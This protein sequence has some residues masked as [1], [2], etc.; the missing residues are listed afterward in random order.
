MLTIRTR[1]IRSRLSSSI[2]RSE[3]QHLETF[4]FKLELLLEGARRHATPFGLTRFCFPTAH[5]T[6]LLVAENRTRVRA[7]DAIGHI[8][9]D[10]VVA[11][12][13]ADRDLARTATTRLLRSTATCRP[14][15]VTTAAFPDDGLTISALLAALADSDERV[16]RLDTGMLPRA[17]TRLRRATDDAGQADAERAS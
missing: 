10:V 3:R 15:E 6:A 2:S 4:W 9:D 17:A 16:H 12:D 11:W 13:H 5:E 8:A 1:P 14:I 7:C